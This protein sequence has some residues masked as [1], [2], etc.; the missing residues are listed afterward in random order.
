MLGH[1]NQKLLEKALGLSCQ[2]VHAVHVDDWTAEFPINS[3]NVYL[4]EFDVF[5]YD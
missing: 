5:L 3:S 4:P 1:H 2:M